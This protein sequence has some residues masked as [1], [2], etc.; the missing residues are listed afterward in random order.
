MNDHEAVSLHEK[1]ESAFNTGDVDALVALYADDGCIVQPDGTA[2]VGPDA[3]RAV[4]EEFVS[5]GGKI[6]M[7][8][9]FA[10]T[11]GDTALLS[12]AWQFTAPG[13]EFGAVSA[14]VAVRGPDGGWR[15]LI[16]NPFGGGEV[17]PPQ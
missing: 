15:Y 11:A 2:A 1:V 14:E 7:T 17:M 3:V 9:R 16:D 13:M 10:I 6:A 4:W 12:N 5:M 8:T